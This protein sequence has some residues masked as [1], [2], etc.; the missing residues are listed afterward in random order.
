VADLC[1]LCGPRPRPGARFR[2]PDCLQPHG[3]GEWLT[4][5]HGT[6]RPW[7]KPHMSVDADREQAM[8]AAMLRPGA[9]V[10][11]GSGGRKPVA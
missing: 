10:T 6:W 5:M 3:G 9:A 2:A 1:F 4:G 11:S 7:L 8:V